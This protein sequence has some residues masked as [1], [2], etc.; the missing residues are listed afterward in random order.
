MY[1][2]YSVVLGE[3]FCVI[4]RGFLILAGVPV[5]HEKVDSAVTE[6]NVL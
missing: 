5:E 3:M 6:W 4:R 2:F 1:D